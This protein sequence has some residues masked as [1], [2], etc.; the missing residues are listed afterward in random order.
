MRFGVLQTKLAVALILHNFKLTPSQRSVNPIE[1][2]PVTL[3]HSPKGDVW[4]NFERIQLE[5]E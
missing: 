2:N 5:V 3:I 4:L 1:V